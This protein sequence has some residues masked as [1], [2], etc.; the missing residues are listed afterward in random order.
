ML[1]YGIG[2][3]EIAFL[4]GSVSYNRRRNRGNLFTVSV[5][6][7]CFLLLRL[8]LALRSRFRVRLGRAFFQSAVFWARLKAPDWAK[9]ALSRA[10]C[11]TPSS[12]TQTG[13]GVSTDRNQR[14]DL[15][16][17][18]PLKSVD[19]CTNRPSAPRRLYAFT[20]PSGKVGK[21]R[22]PALSAGLQTSEFDH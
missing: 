22:T 12:A 1:S 3:F 14:A 5:I 4:F 2:V 10:T 20:A 7:R 17:Q 18:V 16:L 21:L 19:L 15:V 8:G 6:S 13:I 11:K 9:I